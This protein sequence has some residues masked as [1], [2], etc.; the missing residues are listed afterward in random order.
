MQ[1]IVKLLC[2]MY[3]FHI[4][5]IPQKV[6]ELRLYT[7]PKLPQTILVS[8]LNIEYMC[9]GLSKKTKLNFLRIKYMIFRKKIF[10]HI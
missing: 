9:L 7:G 8:F 4:R 2:P 3:F 6:A 5:R 10:A 1:D